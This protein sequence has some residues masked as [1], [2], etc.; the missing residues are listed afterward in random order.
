MSAPHPGAWSI[1]APIMTSENTSRMAAL[2][3][4]PA[5]PPP[6]PVTEVTEELLRSGRAYFYSTSTY[7]VT[8]NLPDNTLLVTLTDPEGGN[9]RYESSWIYGPEYMNEDTWY[10]PLTRSGLVAGLDR[11]G[12]PRGVYRMAFFVDGE[13]ADSFSFELK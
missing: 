5:V 12:Y 10:I 8:E 13:L 7:R 1:R 4:T 3:P 9:Y 6:V 2:T 11:N